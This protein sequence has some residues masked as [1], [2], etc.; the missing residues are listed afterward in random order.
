MEQAGPILK[1]I[2]IAT[3]IVILHIAVIYFAGEKLFERYVFFGPQAATI[4]VNDPT[5]TKEIPTPLPVPSI[6]YEANVQTN[7]SNQS[8]G[9]T[10]SFPGNGLLIPVAGVRPDQLVDAFSD[11]RSGGRIHDAIDIAAPQGSPVLAAVNGKIAR[12]FDSE[13]GGITIYQLTEDGK[14]VLYYAHLQ[15]RADGIIE[16]MAVKKGE[17]IGYVGDTGNAGM[18]NYHL[19]FS[20][21]RVVDPKRYW[22]G[23]YI[24]PYPLLK[25]GG[26]LE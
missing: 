10:Q 5:E 18:G 21:A 6:L 4:A 7:S 12:F 23:T 17:T 15:K 16:G 25:S 26:P 20:I 13:M 14:F 2:F 22:E 24:N 8:P 19:H 11:A 3:Y 1:R 9:S